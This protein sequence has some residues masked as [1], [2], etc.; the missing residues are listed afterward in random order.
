MG[1]VLSQD[2]VDALLDGVVSEDT[3]NDAK[4]E[5]EYDP[6]EIISF[7]PT[8]KATAAGKLRNMLSSKALF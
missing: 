8:I 1:S 6:A 5:D 3:E 7:D 4:E 2:E